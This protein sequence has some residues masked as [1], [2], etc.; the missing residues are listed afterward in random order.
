MAG[1]K[2]E[3]EP[4]T[5]PEKGAATEEETSEAEKPTSSAQ[6]S[7]DN[8]STTIAK[9]NTSSTSYKNVRLKDLAD[10]ICS[11]KADIGILIDGS[12]SVTQ[13]KFAKLL[14]FTQSLVKSF[15]VSQDRT[16]IAVA[17]A[18]RG[19]HMSFDFRGFNDVPSLNTAISRISYLGGP[20]LLGSSLTGVKT[21]WFKNSGRK[22]IPQLLLVLA[23]TTSIDDII[24][25]AR[26]M[27][28]RGVRIESVG[29][30]PEFDGAQLKEIATHPARDH[31]MAI[32][33]FDLL[34]MIRPLLTFRMCRAVGGKLVPRPV[35]EIH[36][37]ENQTMS[38][39]PIL[40]KQHNATN[41]VQ[42][43]PRIQQIKQDVQADQ[44][45]TLNADKQVQNN[46]LAATLKQLDQFKLIRKQ[47]NLEGSSQQQQDKPEKQD[48]SEGSSQQQQ[49]ETEKQDNSEGSSQKQQDETKKPDHSE[50]TSEQQ[51]QDETEK[52]RI[53]KDIRIKLYSLLR[54]L[55]EQRKTLEL[56]TDPSY[57]TLMDTMI[58]N[59]VKTTMA[60]VNSGP[61]ITFV[62]KEM[63]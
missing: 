16:H 12:S 31:V 23:T 13:D 14:D 37:T 27:R 26:V 50:G 15:S 58:A 24:S 7:S 25:P 29:I 59:T 52:E 44:E 34:H 61:Q 21:S 18:S 28:D 40:N 10:K 20:F 2:S 9:N 63:I 3:E 33:K 60:C 43:L 54:R 17:T 39:S 1:M 49:D 19:P 41:K 55:A 22:S 47:D 45:K 46:K 53:R 30:G 4:E 32:S 62:T 48:N 8:T 35:S 5:A 56:L 6:S 51:Q 57:T 36:Q 42:Q 38:N 11:A